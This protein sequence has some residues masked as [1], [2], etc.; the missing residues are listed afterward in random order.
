MSI[1]PMVDSV[2]MIKVTGEQLVQ[3]L[4]NGVS[5]YPK[6]EGR[7]PQVSGLKFTF[8]PSQPCGNRVVSDSVYIS[9]KPMELNRSYKLV[10]KGYIAHGKDGYDVF[11]HCKV[12]VSED[13]GPILGSIVRNH[14]TACSKLQNS[15]SEVDGF[16][17]STVYVVH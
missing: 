16:T 10:T 17:T 11:K 6:L 13:E 2:S 15:Y 3:A 8:D 7:F 5:Q 14:F 12:I 1:L 4:E 9:D